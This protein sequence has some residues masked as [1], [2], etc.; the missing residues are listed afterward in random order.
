MS[1]VLMRL[2][3]RGSPVT[4]RLRDDVVQDGR[5]NWVAISS[6]VASILMGGFLDTQRR[7]MAHPVVNARIAQLCYAAFGQIERW[8][9][10][11]AVWKLGAIV[12]LVELAPAKRTETHSATRES[13]VISSFQ[14]DWHGG[15][16]FHTASA[17]CVEKVRRPQSY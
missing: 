8:L 17:D 11:E 6:D 2:E 14:L 5:V 15:W 10:A 9:W 3:D 7:E 4:R 13:A 1:A 12:A 16:S